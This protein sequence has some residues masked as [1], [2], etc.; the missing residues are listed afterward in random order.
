MPKLFRNSEAYR[1]DFGYRLIFFLH[2]FISL[3][4]SN[5]KPSSASH[6][7]PPFFN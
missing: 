2:H 7:Y 3:I 5:F 1:S 6:L 4:P